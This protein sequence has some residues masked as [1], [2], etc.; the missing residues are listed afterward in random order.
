MAATTSCLTPSSVQSQA[1]WLGAR[2]ATQPQGIQMPPACC[3]PTES[4]QARALA[5][6]TGSIVPEP[7]SLTPHT[8]PVA[9]RAGCKAARRV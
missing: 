9:T 8:Y 5:T 4:R 3:H 7:Q 6:Q 2:T 1:S